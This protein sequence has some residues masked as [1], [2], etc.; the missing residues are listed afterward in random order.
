MISEN[1][2]E[3][4]RT[5]QANP[6][7]MDKFVQPSLRRSHNPLHS[8]LVMDRFCAVLGATRKEIRSQKQNP[9]SAKRRWAVAYVLH[10]ARGIE[11]ANIARIL[12]LHVRSTDHGLKR[13]ADLI[14]TDPEFAS[15]VDAL[16]AVA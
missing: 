4:A 12:N 15:M 10:K 8:A 16:A 6:Y 1:N 5:A 2:T 3:P 13:A 11:P 14:D 9:F 7:S